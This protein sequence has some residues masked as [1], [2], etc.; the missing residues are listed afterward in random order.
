[1]MHF[2]SWGNTANLRN[3]EVRTR[4]K[5]GMT[6]VLQCITGNISSHVTVSNES[7]IYEQ[8]LTY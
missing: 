6:V 3:H 5:R 4:E 2:Y 8:L 7:R 1:M